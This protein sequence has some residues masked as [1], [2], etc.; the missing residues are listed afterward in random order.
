MGF[1]SM[2]K[3]L[4]ITTL[5]LFISSCGLEMSKEISDRPKSNVN[6]LN[7]NEAN[8]I[9]IHSSKGWVHDLTFY[10]D[11]L[12]HQDVEDGLKKA[13]KQWNDALGKNFLT[14]GGKTSLEEYNRQGLYSS[15]NDDITM[16]IVEDD[17]SVKTKKEVDIIG[18]TV[19]ENDVNDESVISKGDIR[20]NAETYLFIDTTKEYSSDDSVWEDPR[21]PVDPETVLVHELGHLIGID[22]TSY[23]QDENSI[24]NPQTNIGMGYSNRKLSSYDKYLVKEI[25]KK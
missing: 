11:E 5:S 4:F 24:M 10:L 23:F 21:I 19:W 1:L 7:E 25:Y 2:K 17:W 3:S 22:H 6:Y 15:L 16:I 20:L 9:P 8:R 14:Y 18:T 13:A 12:A